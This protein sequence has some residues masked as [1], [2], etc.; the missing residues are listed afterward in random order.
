MYRLPAIRNKTRVD[1]I[2]GADTAALEGKVRN[3]IYNLF[4]NQGCG[5]RS[6]WIRMILSC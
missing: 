4:Q 2:Q 5:F 3:R 6:D 1:R